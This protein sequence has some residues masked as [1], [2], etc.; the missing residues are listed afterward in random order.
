M[1]TVKT[2]AMAPVILKALQVS[3][4]HYGR[5]S[6]QK[7]DEK[8]QSKNIKWKSIRDQNIIL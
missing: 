8:I 2:I 6:E 1:K 3:N 5:L 7:R 4:E